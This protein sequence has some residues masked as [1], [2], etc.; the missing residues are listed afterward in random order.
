MDGSQYPDAFAVNP[1]MF[2]EVFKAVQHAP[3]GS[4]Q[5]GQFTSESSGSAPQ[6]NPIELKSGIKINRG[7]LNQWRGGKLN[8]VRMREN[9]GRV[10]TTKLP[11]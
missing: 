4:P 9:F 7:A 8:K 2:C 10:A 3:A 11:A 6:S 1:M 5:G